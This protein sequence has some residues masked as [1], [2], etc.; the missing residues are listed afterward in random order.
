M[1]DFLQ[2][3]WSNL[4]ALVA[5]TRLTH[6]YEYQTA[7]VRNRYQVVSTNTD[8]YLEVYH[9]TESYE[10]KKTK[11]LEVAEGLSKILEWRS[12]HVS[13][14]KIDRQKFKITFLNRMEMWGSIG[15]YDAVC[16]NLLA[17]K[18]GLSRICGLLLSFSTFGNEEKN[19]YV[20]ALIKDLGWRLWE[21]KDK[22]DQTR[23]KISFKK[24]EDAR[25]TYHLPLFDLL[26]IAYRIN[27]NL[28]NPD[29]NPEAE[30]FSS[31]EP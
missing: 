14:A 20:N 23:H 6:A 18:K 3:V 26:M 21:V 7:S 16:L 19:T 30:I 15:E 5:R 28:P 25:F 2:P 1:G 8:S 31:K 4:L 24:S 9:V 13:L 11:I 27:P 12:Y 29:F 17:Q 22:Y 10:Q